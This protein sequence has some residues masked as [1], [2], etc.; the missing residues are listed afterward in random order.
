MSEEDECIEQH[1]QYTVWYIEAVSFRHYPEEGEHLALWQRE[2][3]AVQM[4]F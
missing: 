4:N 2:D 1:S 3:G